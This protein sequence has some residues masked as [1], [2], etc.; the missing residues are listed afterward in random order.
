MFNRSMLIDYQK[1]EAKKNEFQLSLS[2]RFKLIVQLDDI[3]LSAINNHITDVLLTSATKVGGMKKHN[4]Q[5]KISE[6][7][8]I[9]DEN[10]NIIYQHEAILNTLN[11]ARQL[12]IE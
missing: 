8:N 4:Q 7:T 6:K 3:S 9:K 2:N 11:C 1:L 10:E 12:G 5:S